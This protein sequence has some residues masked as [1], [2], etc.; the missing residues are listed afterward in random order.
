MSS[1]Q[2]HLLSQKIKKLHKYTK[3]HDSL[4]SRVFIQQIIII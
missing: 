2:M 1:E 3:T 4:R